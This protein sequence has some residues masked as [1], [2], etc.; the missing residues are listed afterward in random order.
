MPTATIWPPAIAPFRA[1][2]DDPVGRLDDFQIVFDNEHG[3]AGIDKA[4]QDV[5]EQPDVGKVEAG[6]RFVEHVEGLTGA[7][8]D[9]FAGEFDPLGF[10]AGER[11]RGLAE[12]HVVEAHVVERLELVADV[13]D[14]LEMDESPVGR[15][16]PARQR[17]TGP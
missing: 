16:F 10:A 7:L 11:R 15:P 3:V 8:L 13:G 1:Q 5:E 17:W 14:V 6:C 4:V 2:V 12:L 9:Q